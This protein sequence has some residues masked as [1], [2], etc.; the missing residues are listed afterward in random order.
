MSIKY[1][2]SVDM[3]ALR[4]AHFAVSQRLPL[5][6]IKVKQ[7]FERAY[8][9]IIVGYGYSIEHLGDGEYVISKASTSLL[10]DTSVCYAVTAS[11]CT[12]PD[13]D[14]ARAGLCKHRMAV[15]VV[16]EMNKINSLQDSERVAQ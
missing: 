12:C 2:S 1:A 9:D 7:R 13:Y 11:S 15:M 14:T 6:D 10:D 3:Q 5:E 16:A 4:Q 8:N